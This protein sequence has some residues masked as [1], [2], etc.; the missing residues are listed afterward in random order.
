MEWHHKGSPLP[1]KFK[2][3]L[4]AGKIMTGMMLWNS[5]GVI[6]VDFLLHGATVNS[7]YYFNLLC[8]DVHQKI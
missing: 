1:K 2:T 5:E 3:Q 8:N 4:S 7:Q 6:H